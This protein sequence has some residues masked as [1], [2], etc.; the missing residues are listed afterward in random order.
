MFGMWRDGQTDNENQTKLR[1]HNIT[2]KRQGNM[3]LHLLLLLLFITLGITTFIYFYFIHGSGKNPFSELMLHSPK[4]IVMNPEVRKKVLKRAFSPEAV[5]PNLDAI[6]IGSGIGGLSVAVVLAKAGK[7]VLVLE[8]HGRAGGCCHTFQE[9]GFEFDVGIHYVGEV[10]E[11]SMMR[12]IMDQL[13]DGH[14]DWVHLEDPYDLITLG[15]KEYELYS[16]KKAFVEELERQFP[17]EKEAIKEFM[18]LSSIV[19]WHIPLLAMLKMI[20]MWLSASLIRWGLVHWVSPVF[21][22]ATSSQSKIVEQLT[23]NQ[24]LRAV[25]SYFFY[26]VPPKDSS[27]LMTSLLVRHYQRGSWYP[28]GGPSE[29]P[30]HMIPIIERAGGAVLMK[31]YVTEILLSES[32]AAVGVSVEKKH[33]GNVKVYAPVVISDA[34]LF[35]TFGKLLPPQIRSKPEIQSQLGLVQHSMGSFIVFVGLR[36]TKEELGISSSNYWIYQHN[37]L[38]SI[39]SKCATLSREE[40]SAHLPMVY[41][42]FP[43]AKDPIYEEK[44]PGHSCMILITMTHYKWFE[45]W[46][47]SLP[48]KRGADYDAFKMEIAQQLL[49]IALAKFP[50]LS[51]KIE[52]MEAASPLT[53][54]Y[55]L[56]AP[57]GEMY[58]AEHDLCRFSP[59]VMAAMR[60]KTP[61]QNLYLT[62]QD[63]FCCGL[64]G[65]LNGGLLCASSVLGRNVYLDLVKL[66]RKLNNLNHKKEA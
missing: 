54:Q 32:G 30:F 59:L 51:D 3:W 40:V 38:D 6:V 37:D 34:G 24:D 62:G 22:L 25:L 39:A 17:K 16:G 10:H 4:P 61:V 52:V 66:K 15:D 57:R 58:G 42:T 31:G 41:I 46:S 18:R 43:S 14:L 63:V 5:P 53:N 50:Q 56:A 48:K 60:P 29:I 35:N 23:N 11:N 28:K 64:A 55:Y 49:D 12:M 65:A 44:R 2:K 13:T 45:E 1:T 21:R 27:F 33:G 47:K 36:G 26:G 7:R 19:R 20:P 9:K 8:Q